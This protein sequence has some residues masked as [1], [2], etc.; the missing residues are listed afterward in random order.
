MKFLGYIAEFA[1]TMKVTEKSDVYSFGVLVV[2]VIKGRHP[3]DLI[4]SLLSPAKRAGVMLEDLLD[5]RLLPPQRETLDQLLDILKLAVACLSENPQ[6]RPTMK[7]VSQIL[8]TLIA[9]YS[10]QHL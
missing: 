4:L 3:G 10:L 7:D 1:Y 2:E 9:K 5:D 6:S 8:S